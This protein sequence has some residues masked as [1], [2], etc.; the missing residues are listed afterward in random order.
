MIAAATF[1]TEPFATT[2]TRLIVI[3]GAIL[4]GLSAV[5]YLLVAYTRLVTDA[6]GLTLYQIGYVQRVA[7]ED[8]ER[9]VLTPGAAGLFLR[10]PSGRLPQTGKKL[11]NTMLP[12]DQMEAYVRGQFLV[13]TPFMWRWEGP[14]GEDFR[15]YVPEFLPAD[16]V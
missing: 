7:W 8:I 4:L 13:L 1:Y 3:L 14:L 5:F 6:K 2:S 11:S 10:K 12:S 15:R 16:P 9:V